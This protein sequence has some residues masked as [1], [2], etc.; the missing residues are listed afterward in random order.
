[1]ASNLKGKGGFSGVNTVIV[2]YDKSVHVN[3]KTGATTQ[4]LDVQVDAR[5]PRGKDDTN[6]HL[7][8]E[9]HQA[10][11]QTRY[12]NGAAYSQRQFEAI[13]EAAGPNQE[14]VL[15]VQG[16]RV[17][18]LYAVKADVTKAAVGNGLIINTKAD[19]DGNVHIGQSDFKVEKD[20]LANQFAAMR[21]AKAAL[22]ESK[23]AKAANEKQA[24]APEQV[25]ESEQ[26]AEASTSDLEPA[27]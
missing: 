17:G 13:K 27:F 8:S 12:S 21:A 16:N 23:A 11:G 24:D 19:K 14:P 20:T 5:D 6:L 2:A 3:E 4:W 15:D 7:Y 9:R 25:Q 10:N 18:T 1:M 22:Q 26:Q